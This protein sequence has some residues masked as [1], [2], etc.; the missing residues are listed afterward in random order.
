VH[1]VFRIQIPEIKESKQ[2][3]IKSTPSDLE[4]SRVYKIIFQNDEN[5]HGV[6]DGSTGIISGEEVIDSHLLVLILLI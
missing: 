5:L 6:L 2:Y 3:N 1:N 4:D